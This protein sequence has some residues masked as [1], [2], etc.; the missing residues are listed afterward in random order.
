MT[1]YPEVAA[2]W[3]PSNAASADSVAAQSN[4]KVEWVCSKDSRHVWATQ[5][6][7]RTANGAGCPFCSGRLSVAGETDLATTH[8]H[9][10]KLWSPRNKQPMS[11]VSR[12]SHA[13]VEW[14]CEKGHYWKAAVYNVAIG[15]S[16]CGV[17]SGKE[18]LYGDNDISTTHPLIAAQW[19]PSNT[20]SPRAVT[21]GSRAPIRWQCEGNTSHTWVASPF[22]RTNPSNPTGCPECW[23]SQMVSAPEI[24]VFEFV[25]A[26]LGD[27][28]EVLQGYRRLKGVHEV[29]VFV[30]SLGIAIEFNGVY[31]HSDKAGKDRYYHWGRRKACEDN[32]VRLISVW[33]DD[34]TERKDV[35]KDMLRVRLGTFRGIKLNARVLEW[36][37]V[38]SRDATAFLEAN[39]IQGAAKSS[40]H[41]GLYTFSGELVAV[42]ATTCSGD[43][44]TIDRFATK[45][46][47]RGAFGKLLKVLERRVG[48][49]GGGT[50]RTF[51]DLTISNGAL[52]TAHGFR[53][54]KELP[55]AYW[56]LVGS[57]RYHTLSFKKRRFKDDST[58]KWD[59]NLSV[60][61]LIDL[62][63]LPRVYDAG[64]LRFVK[65]VPS[66][67]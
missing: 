65:D 33:E 53:M 22:N 49:D 17:C 6:C 61:E 25:K 3:S 54:D 40:R 5:V 23:A 15:G 36:R 20:A 16:G 12:G 14:R 64:K 29:D 1:L 45:G 13:K 10:A 63:N 9:L 34:W 58:L 57:R 27:A 56:V 66:T 38:P 24:E 67:A 43:T 41:D 30:P 2:E 46:N 21:A 50:L 8:P 44:Y 7:T 31:W 11:S 37:R 48:A 42:L 39:H 47:V 18:V 52:Y 35:V 55:P 59:E 26:E 60:E 62:N 19:H 32:S 28:V 4:A 51:A